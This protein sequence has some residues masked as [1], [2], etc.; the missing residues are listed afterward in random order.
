MFRVLFD[1]TVVCLLAY[2]EGDKRLLWSMRRKK[3]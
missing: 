1:F 2:S 3:A